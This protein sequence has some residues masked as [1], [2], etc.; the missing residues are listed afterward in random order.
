MPITIVVGDY[1]S[2]PIISVDY[3]TTAEDAIRL[4]VEKNVGALAVKDKESYVGI[5]TERDIL[6]KCCGQKSCGKMGV[7][8]IMNKPLVTLDTSA[9]LGEAV[10]LMNSK[11]IRRL[12][13]TKKSKIVGII[14]ERDLLK[15]TLETFKMMESALSLI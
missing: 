11:K 6:K 10:A 2:T 15:G 4:M 1:M 5:I 13:I 14:T 9:K 8:E 7:N 3:E 12:L